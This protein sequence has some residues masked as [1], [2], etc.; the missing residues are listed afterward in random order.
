MLVGWSTFYIYHLVSPFLSESNL[1]RRMSRIILSPPSLN[2]KMRRN[3]RSIS[4]LNGTGLSRICRW[5]SRV[6]LKIT[7]KGFN[8]N[9]PLMFKLILQLVLSWFEMYLVLDHLELT[10]AAFSKVLTL[11]E[12]IVTFVT[13]FDSFHKVRMRVRTSLVSKNAQMSAH[14]VVRCIRARTRSPININSS[15]ESNLTRK[16]ERD[17]NDMPM[18]LGESKAI[19]CHC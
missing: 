11:Y 17:D 1:F 3:L 10:S 14:S 18:V 8:N 7:L 16:R 6:M 4:V 12:T 13:R 15:P 9:I 19:P 5:Y 2:I